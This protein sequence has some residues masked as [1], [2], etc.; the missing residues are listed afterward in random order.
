VGSVAELA[1]SGIHNH[2]H[3]SQHDGGMTAATPIKSRES[4]LRAL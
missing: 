2:Y 1:K 3:L 4:L